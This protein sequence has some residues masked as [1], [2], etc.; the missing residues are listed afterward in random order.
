MAS[1]VVRY[2]VVKMNS[3]TSGNANVKN[4]LDGVRQYVRCS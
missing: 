2:I 1:D 3:S 4:A